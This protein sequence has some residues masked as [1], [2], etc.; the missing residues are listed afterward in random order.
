MPILD[1]FNKK[2]ALKTADKTPYKVFT[3]YYNNLKFI[4][5]SYKL[6]EF[7]TNKNLKLKY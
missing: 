2:E 3:P 7:E 1:W 6:E 4:W 5:D